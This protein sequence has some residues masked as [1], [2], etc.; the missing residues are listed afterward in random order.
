MRSSVGKAYDLQVEGGAVCAVLWCEG[1]HPS[2]EGTTS[3][4]LMKVG[5]ENA[6]SREDPGHAQN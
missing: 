4:F 5:F 1:R 3:H 6:V 2:A